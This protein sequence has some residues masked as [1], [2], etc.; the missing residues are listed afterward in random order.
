MYYGLT[1]GW[2]SLINSGKRL[3]LKFFNYFLKLSSSIFNFIKTELWTN[4]P[5]AKKEWG[6]SS[7]CMS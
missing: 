2:H 5:L 6:L 4:T 1:S 3:V 7:I